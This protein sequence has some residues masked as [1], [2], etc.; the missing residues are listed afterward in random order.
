MSTPVPPRR[1]VPEPHLGFPV[2]FDG[3]GR[4]ALVDDESYLRG[5]VELVLFTTPGERVNRP[6]FGSGI[7]ALVFEPAGD[8]LSQST[9]ALVQGALQQWLGHLILVDRVEI[10]VVEGRLD[11]A[12]DYRP[13]R[14]TGSAGRRRLVTSR[15]VG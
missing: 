12:V 1:L 3:R 5:L 15:G 7:H 10:T 13:V 4:T 2:R 8:T 9:Q 14:T 11:V 6:D